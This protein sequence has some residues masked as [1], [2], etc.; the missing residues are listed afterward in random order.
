MQFFFRNTIF[1]LAAIEFRTSNNV[2]V[3]NF[4]S[5]E[6]GEV[7]KNSTKIM[8]DLPS[9]SCSRR[10][11]N[12]LNTTL[13]QIKE[14]PTG[15]GTLSHKRMRTKGTERDRVRL[16]RAALSSS[17]SNKIVAVNLKIYRKGERWERRL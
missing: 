1:F 14:T 4:S 6:G 7:F 8:A 13:Q 15:V 11:L 3:Q 17:L 2:S 9:T 5:T 16:Q 10:G 12:S